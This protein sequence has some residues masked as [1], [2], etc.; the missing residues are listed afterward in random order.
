LTSDELERIW[1]ES[2]AAFVWSC[3]RRPLKVVDFSAEN[4]NIILYVNILEANKK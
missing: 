3:W 1:K 2:L 4:H